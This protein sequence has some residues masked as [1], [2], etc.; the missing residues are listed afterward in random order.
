MNRTE[1]LAHFEQNYVRPKAL[2]K[3]LQA[4]EYLWQHRDEL[5]G[6]L[7]ESLRQISR[8]I[9]AMQRTGELER[10][11]Y[12][13][14]SLLRSAFFT[15]KPVY[16]I[17]VYNKEW[18]FDPEQKECTGVYDAAAIYRYL[19]EFE[20]ELDTPRR[21]YLNQVTPVDLEQIRLRE[22]AEFN[23]LIISLAEYTFNQGEPLRELTEIE[24]ED[25]FEIRVGEYYDR[26]EVVYKEDLRVKDAATVKEWLEAKQDN[27]YEAAVIQNL[28]LA[29][30]DY[31]GI[32]LNRANLRG[33]NLTDS[34]LENSVLVKARFTGCNMQRAK[35]SYA[36][37]HDADFS[38]ADL[39]KA[40]F[41][42]AEGAKGLAT[43]METGIYSV[44]GVKFC[45]A[46]LSGADFRFANL[47]GADF[48]GAQLA[49]TNF[50][51]AKLDRAFFDQAALPLLNWDQTQIE[52][53][54]W[55]E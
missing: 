51:G 25:E 15:Q 17:D 38:R 5:A 14:Y 22:A 49:Q 9:K 41:F 37:I 8:K 42:A 21:R 26:S 6:E 31:A 47:T 54:I 13:N 7:R 33:S 40:I 45:G 29:G 16:R 35:L 43:T 27:R 44:W 32:D 52:S 34:N 18:Y 10:V 36:A 50:Q 46:N 48:T 30:G 39:T 55:V 3:L 1:A 28:D 19:A 20:R 24:R 11:G 12:I 2:E 23:Q 53:I 4:E